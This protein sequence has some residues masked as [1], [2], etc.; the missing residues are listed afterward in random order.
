MFLSPMPTPLLRVQVSLAV[1]PRGTEEEGISVN[2][3]REKEPAKAEITVNSRV[4]VQHFGDLNQ[5]G[6]TE[7]RS[8]PQDSWACPYLYIEME[9]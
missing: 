3:V 6:L 1:D 8:S 7:F 9:K 2:I 4:D 5:K